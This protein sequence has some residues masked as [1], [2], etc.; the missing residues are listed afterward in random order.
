[1]PKPVQR[2]D[3]V[4]VNHTVKSIATLESR[5]AELSCRC[6]QRSRPG[7]RIEGQR[8]VQPVAVIVGHED[9]EDPLKVLLIQD[10]QPIEAL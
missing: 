2:R 3:A 7:G 1:M 9:L 5:G 10:Q 8:S 6:D 4:L